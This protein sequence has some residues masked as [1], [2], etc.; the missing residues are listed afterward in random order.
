MPPINHSLSSHRFPTS[1]SRIG[2]ALLVTALA[3][4]LSG[5]VL[6]LPWVD[7]ET[8]AAKAAERGYGSTTRDVVVRT[9]GQYGYTGGARR[10]A[11]KDRLVQRFVVQLTNKEPAVRTTA[12]TSL[13]MLGRR[14]VPAVPAL[15]KALSDPSKNVRRAA[16]RSLGK[17]KSPDAVDPLIASLRDRDKYVARTA[18]LALR[19]IGTEKAVRAARRFN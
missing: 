7:T 9:P 6:F 11:A 3:A 15:V 10:S 18:A 4:P 5:C 2:G 1:F 8:E 17:I 13:G 16:A 14:A 19:N 12:A